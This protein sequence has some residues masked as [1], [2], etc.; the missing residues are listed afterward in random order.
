MR[1]SAQGTTTGAGRP[2]IQAA[3]WT[4]WWA[5]APVTT[6][7]GPGAARSRARSRAT[8]LDSVPPLVMRASGAG[9]SG[10]TS[11][12]R[13]AVVSSSITPAAGA[14]SQESIEGLRAAPATSAATATARGGQC[15]WATQAG[16]AGSAAPS[17]TARTRSASAASAPTPS[18]GSTGSHRAA[19]RR[20][21]ASGPPAGRGPP[22]A[23]AAVS[24]V[25]RTTEVRARSRPGPSAPP[26]R[27][28]P[29]PLLTP[30][31]PG[32]VGRGG[33]GSEHAPWRSPSIGV[34]DP[35]PGFAG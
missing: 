6:R 4:L 7:R 21:T 29:V 19:V 10:W 13:A 9:A 20:A 16:S 28:S 30:H 3:R 12:A 34:Q 26:A 5:L 31:A 17:A 22:R 27:R 1:P 15:R 33:T 14:W 23:R 32:G 25:S 11:R 18:S 24:S 8:R 35:Q 2:S